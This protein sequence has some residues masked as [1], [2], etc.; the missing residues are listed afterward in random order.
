MPLRIEP[1]DATFGAVV[2]GLRLAELD[3]DQFDE[4]YRAWLD[5]ALLI[6]PGQHL[7]NA[8]Q[9]TFAR[10]FGDLEFDLAPL[11]NVRR[12]GSLR[13]DDDSDDVVKVLKGNM[14][15][16]ADSTYMPVQAKG[17]V[18]TAH[19]VP[20]AGGETGWADMRAAY[21]ALDDD[22][23]QR[24]SGLSARHSLYYSQAKLGHAPKPGS[25]YSGYGFHDQEP[26]LRPLVKVHPETGRRSLLIG[27]H[28]HGIPGMTADESER[29]LD[30]LVTFACQAPRIYH[31]RWAPGD[32]VLWDNRCLLHRARPWDMRE[33]RIMFHSRIAG[34]PASESAEAA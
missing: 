16:H 20:P 27:R 8:G 5:Y 12:D 3:A 21:D 13:A 22:L 19:V 9:V 4:L 24:V 18:F 14:G 1:L 33:P 26:P 15:W 31:H 17:A 7:D 30:G 6:F 32:A 25:D 11:S 10:R 34:D 23:R 29:L 2:S 28:A